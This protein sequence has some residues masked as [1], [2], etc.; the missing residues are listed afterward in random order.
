MEK[1][2][3]SPVVAVALLLVISVSAVV[4]FQ[5]W[6]QTYQ[7][8][9]NSD[10]E[11]Q[12]STDSLNTNIETIVGENLYFK[13]NNA[14]NNI[15]VDSI[16][17]NGINCE[18]TNG[19]YSGKIIKFN[20]SSCLNNL[21]SNTPDILI[22][23][24][25]KIYEKKIYLKEITSNPLS[26]IN[27]SQV[28]EEWITNNSGTQDLTWNSFNSDWS[29]TWTNLKLPSVSY[30][31]SNPSG[32]L[33]FQGMNIGNSI[34]SL[35]SLRRVGGTL[36]LY[37]NNLTDSDLEALSNLERVNNTLAL[38]DNNLTN[39]SALSN[40][41]YVGLLNIGNNPLEDIYGLR[42]VMTNTSDGA[43]VE[44]PNSVRP[45]SVKMPS[46]AWLC[47]PSNANEWWND[48]SFISQVDACDCT[49]ANT[50]YICD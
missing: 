13:N 18:G 21:T 17:I 22:I 32:D 40:L 43:R 36:E 44:I 9:I 42:N 31:I 39:L 30:P 8:Q 26:A 12:G 5:T 35:D 23:T 27:R 6:F 7:S 50:D 24:K 4:S 1:K 33:I 14:N 16:K 38:G 25:D 10:I 29:L 2:A 47:Q 3:I 20:V 28:W 34:Q 49:D 45:L 15:T 19:S 37:S 41:V 48:S 11:S 46:S